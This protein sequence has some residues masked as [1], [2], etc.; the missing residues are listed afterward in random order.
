MVMFTNQQRL[1]II[2]NY[3][4]NS[5]SVVATLRALTPIFGRNNRPTGQAVRAIVDKFKTKFTLL[6]VPVPKRRRVARSEEKVAAVS[7]S[8]QNEPNQLIPRRSQE[9]SITQTTL[10]RIMREYLGLH[11]FKIKLTQELKPLNH[12]K[13]R[14][15]SNWGLAKLK[16]NEEFHRKIIFSDKAHF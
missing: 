14:N 10:W 13:R 7:A 6:D 2:K 12:L 4:R 1:E 15:F 5:E 11:A 3:Y 9:L 8:I 16:E